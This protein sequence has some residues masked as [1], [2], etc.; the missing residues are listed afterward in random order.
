MA[1][2]QKQQLTLSIINP[3]LYQGIEVGQIDNKGI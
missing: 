2:K 3:N 1:K